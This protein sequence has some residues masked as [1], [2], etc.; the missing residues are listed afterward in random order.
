MQ[1]YQLVRYIK[2]SQTVQD[3]SL[4]DDKRE[5]KEKASKGF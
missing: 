1:A 3:K 2:I 4:K 5:T